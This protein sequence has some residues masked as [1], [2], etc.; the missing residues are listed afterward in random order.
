MNRIQSI[1]L[2][3]MDSDQLPRRLMMAIMFAFFFSV[4]GKVVPDVYYRF[5]DTTKYLEIKS[6]LSVDKAYYKPCEGVKVST[7]ITSRLDL[8]ADFFTELILVQENSGDYTRIEGSGITLRTPIIQA[9]PHVVTNMLP[10]P[11]NLPD[12]LYHWKGNAEYD[13]RGYERVEPYF[14]E[15]FQVTQSGLSPAG[16][17]L[18]EQI[19][20][21]KE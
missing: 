11:C 9:E 20:Q 2:H 14:S 1:T 12:G 17:D 13:V 15:T 8:D 19:D 21:L 3:Y 7:I 10:L 6:P 4:V 16:E 5:F 18:Q